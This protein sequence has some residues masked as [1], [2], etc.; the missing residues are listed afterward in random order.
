[1]I[2][3][4]AYDKW[5]TTYYKIIDLNNK[6]IFK[7]DTLTWQSG[8]L[9]H[10]L[11]TNDDIGSFA[12]ITFP[13]NQF[14]PS[15]ITVIDISGVAT[16]FQFDNYSFYYLERFSVNNQSILFTDPFGLVYVFRTYIN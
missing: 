2:G 3:Y 5:D 4:I 9:N 12:L 8:R 14:L 13:D 15:I 6:E 1:M 10:Y 7:Y 11:V 16:D